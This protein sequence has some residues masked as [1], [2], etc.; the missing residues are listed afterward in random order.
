MNIEQKILNDLDDLRKELREAEPLID[1]IKLIQ[2]D[3]PEVTMWMSPRCHMGYNPKWVNNLTDKERRG[4]VKHELFHYINGHF[5]RA[6]QLR[7]VYGHLTKVRSNVAMDLEINCEIEGLPVDGCFVQN[8]GFPPKLTFEKYYELLEGQNPANYKDKVLIDDVIYSDDENEADIEES[9]MEEVLMEVEESAKLVGRSRGWGSGKVK[10]K[11]NVKPINIH[12]YLK[13]LFNRLSETPTF[14]FDHTIYSRFKRSNIPDILKFKERDF[15]PVMKI[16]FGVDTSS[17]RS[18][19]QVNTSMSK[20]FHTLKNLGEGNTISDLY[21]IDSGVSKV[22]RLNHAHDIPK[23]FHGR[24][25]TRMDVIYKQFKKNSYDLV[26]I[27]T[28]AYLN[29]DDLQDIPP[30]Y[31]KKTVVGIDR[32]SFKDHGHKFNVPVFVQ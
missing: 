4:V 12:N 27:L 20:I 30:K 10:I 16:A 28:D 3:G 21:E 25:G 31:A 5:L 18:D 8:F 9:I 22:T 6:R 24:G 23:E 2:D 32:Q 29:P 7:R 15:V 26:I 17:S 14:G 11:K 19:G 1:R 13:V